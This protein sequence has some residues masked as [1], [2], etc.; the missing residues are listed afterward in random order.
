MSEELSTSQR[1]ERIVETRKKVSRGFKVNTKV[2]RRFLKK[3][4]IKGV[5]NDRRKMFHYSGQF[6]GYI[7]HGERAKLERRAI[8]SP[9]IIKRMFLLIIE[10]FHLKLGKALPGSTISIGGEEKKLKII[11]DLDASKLRTLNLAF[12]KQ[13]TQDATK[14]NKCLSAD[15][16]LMMHKTFFEDEVRK[17]LGLPLTTKNEKLFLRICEALHWILSTTCYAASVHCIPIKKKKM[18]FS[19]PTKISLIESR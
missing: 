6:C 5:G 3:V 16:F 7:K 13:A 2:K 10:D 12:V 8:A 15:L 14:F 19:R 9:N 18:S 11:T 4:T 1:G 17:E